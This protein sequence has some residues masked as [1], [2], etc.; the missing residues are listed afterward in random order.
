MW[1]D[2][3]TERAGIPREKVKGRDE[4]RGGARWERRDR[5]S[6]MRVNRPREME[7][8]IVETLVKVWGQDTSLTMFLE[9]E[10]TNELRIMTKETKNL[11]EPNQLHLL[12]TG[13]FT[14]LILFWV[15]WDTK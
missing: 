6:G 7:T 2:S 14:T 3:Q 8:L 13:L 11:Q 15:L 4:K 9:E 12:T 5:G 1:L 10:Q